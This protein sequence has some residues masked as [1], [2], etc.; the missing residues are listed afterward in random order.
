MST[1]RSFCKRC[2]EWQE[3]EKKTISITGYT[4]CP[5]CNKELWDVSLIG[6]AYERLKEDTAGGKTADYLEID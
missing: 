1:V 5:T 4:I 3:V 6:F 2:S